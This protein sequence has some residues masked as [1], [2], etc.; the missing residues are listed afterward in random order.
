MREDIMKTLLTFISLA[1]LGGCAYPPPGPPN[2]GTRF[3]PPA[4]PSQWHVVSVTPVAPG[5]GEQ[6]A[7]SSGKGAAAPGSSVQYSSPV[8]TTEPVYVPQ[9]VVVPQPV[10]VAP[11][12]YY[13]PPPYYAPAPYY[14]PPVSIGLDFVFG[15]S[16]GGHGRNWGGVGIGSRWHR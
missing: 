3:P 15:R 4:D 11:P 6:L 16:W 12:Y 1:V 10:Y 5:A 2:Y 7:A 8:T 13:A 9:P 14:Y